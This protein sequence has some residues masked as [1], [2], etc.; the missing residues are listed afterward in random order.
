MTVSGAVGN[1]DFPFSFHLTLLLQVF[2]GNT[3]RDTVVSRDLY[4]PIR[5]RYIRFRPVSWE[6]HISMRV[7][8]Y[9]CQGNVPIGKRGNNINYFEVWEAIP[10][11]L[12]TSYSYSF[13]FEK[14]NKAKHI[15]TART[16][17]ACEV[18]KN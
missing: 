4:P 16:D 7:E 5:V 13:L 17:L 15:T 18:A 3:D 2:T 1:C 8:L 9:G 6:G 11:P 14:K 10:D 12:V